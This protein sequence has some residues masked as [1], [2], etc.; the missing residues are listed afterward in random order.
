MTLNELKKIV[1][2]FEYDYPNDNGGWFHESGQAFYINDD[3]CLV[4]SNATPSEFYKGMEVADIY[5][6]GI[7]EEFAGK[8]NEIGEWLDYIEHSY[9]PS[10]VRKLKDKWIKL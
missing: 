10:D 7:D 6:E 5:N 8:I 1:V 3:N 2:F 9:I 4:M